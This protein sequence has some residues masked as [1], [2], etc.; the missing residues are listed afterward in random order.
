MSISFLPKELKFFDFLSLQADNIVKASDCFKAS[1]KKGVFDDETVRK[2]KNF[3]HEG[4]TL[5]H[6]IVDMLNR[7]FITPIDREDIYAL[8][9]T[10]DDILDMI[11]SMSNRIKLYKLNANEE[12][13]VQFADTIDQ[14]AHALTNAVK[15]MHDTKRARRV[16][17]YCIEVNRLENLGD[18]I[19][20]KAISNLFETEKDPIMVIKWK[21][22]Y[23][24]AEGTLDTC[25]H[26]AKVIE[27][28]LVK[29]G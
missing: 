8:A 29:N 25:E 16:L 3:E 20:E 2:I 26:V 17:D 6:E 27:S 21:E 13:M 11:N 7:T 23:E 12:C 10:L 9:N 4:D 28:I 24:V 19:R 22:I 18:Q 5:S 14:S 1:V 15:H